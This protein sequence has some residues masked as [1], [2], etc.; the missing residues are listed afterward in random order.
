MEELVHEEWGAVATRG[1][2][3][4][5]GLEDPQGRGDENRPQC[6]MYGIGGGKFQR[7]EGV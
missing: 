4:I 6:V 5:V 3:D 1:D 2:C 7:G